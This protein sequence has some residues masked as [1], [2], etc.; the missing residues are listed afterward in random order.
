MLKSKFCWLK[1]HK[2]KAV[3]TADPSSYTIQSMRFDCPR[4][5]LQPHFATFLLPPSLRVSKCSQNPR[6]LFCDLGHQNSS[7]VWVERAQKSNSWTAW[8]E[9]FLFLFTVLPSLFVTS[10]QDSFSLK[11]NRKETMCSVFQSWNKN[12]LRF[13][14]ISFSKICCAHRLNNSASLVLFHVD[15]VHIYKISSPWIAYIAHRASVPKYIH[16]NHIHRQNTFWQRRE[17]WVLPLR[18]FKKRR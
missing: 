2:C 16:I 8:W 10:T 15:A 12:K 14:S 9:G 11:F 6:I 3:F 1:F 4:L 5:C 18:C 13:G 7:F 17:E